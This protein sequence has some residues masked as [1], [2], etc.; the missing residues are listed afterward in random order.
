M[1][2]ALVSE[3]EKTFPGGAAIAAGFTLEADA[4]TVTV[5]FGPSGSGKTT[6]L[7]CLAGLE[8]PDRGFIR[9]GD[10]TWFDGACAIC[11]PPQARRIGYL[12]QEYALF[13]HL[14][15]S[16][17]IGFGVS[18]PRPQRQARVT[19][20][21]EA[22]QLRGLETRYPPRLSGGQQQRVALA[23]ALATQPRVLLLDEPLSALDAPT[24]E[25][26]RRELRRVLTRY[27]I[28]TLLV[29]HDRVEAL[30]LG[31][32][33]LV[34]AGGRIRQA[35]PVHE[36]FSRPADLTVA[37]TVGVETVMPG[38]VVARAD[39]LLTVEAGSAR[40]TACDP[41]DAEGDVFV[42]IRAEEVVLE[43]G[44]L[45]RMS[46]RNHFTGGV[47]AIT[48]EGPLLRVALDCGFPLAALITRP[49]YEELGLAVGETVTAVVKAMS[50][51]LIP[52]DGSRSTLT[53]HADA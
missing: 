31:D 48:P 46:A 45:P 42:C 13:P 51:H 35:G 39:G 19:G 21:L 20:L 27:G 33:M 28:P 4:A 18:G 47:T 1:A 43:R 5:L 38:R 49:A 9:C 10:A 44:P 37:R 3:F 40:L 7:R 32:R 30:T 52:R 2:V 22:L 14:T 24:R 6:I 12:S 25:I 8:R 16:Q 26:L 15:V 17:N 53:A 23:R 41:G 29:T 34:I 36:V 50:V 11:V